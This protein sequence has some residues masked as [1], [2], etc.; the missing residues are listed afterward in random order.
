M[1]RPKQAQQQMP[2]ESAENEN[3]YE[4]SYIR[5]AEGVTTNVVSAV[6]IGGLAILSGVIYAGWALVLSALHA[7]SGIVG[8]LAFILLGAVLMFV[9]LVIVIVAWLRGMK[10][11]AL[12]GMLIGA[13]VG[14]AIGASI[15]AGKWKMHPWASTWAEEKKDT[16]KPE[17]E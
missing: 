4:W 5:V 11:T 2:V 12:A 1:D 10:S 13:I 8:I 9:I 3:A 7:P 15:D 16:A 6:I 14:A 17:S